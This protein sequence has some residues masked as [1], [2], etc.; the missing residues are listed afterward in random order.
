LFLSASFCA[1]SLEQPTAADANAM[2]IRQIPDSRKSKVVCSI[3]LAD[4][5]ELRAF[6]KGLRRIIASLEHGAALVAENEPAAA[7]SRRAIR[8]RQIG[9]PQ[10]DDEREAMVAQAR[11]R[12]RFD[13]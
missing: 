4:P 9:Q 12:L 3:T 11:D 13:L 8:Q 7:A 1:R 2:K 6:F 5:D 10:H